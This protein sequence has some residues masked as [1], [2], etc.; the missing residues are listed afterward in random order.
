MTAPIPSNA[1]KPLV[2]CADDYALDAGVSQAIRTLAR[3]GRLSATS[4]MTLSPRWRE[5][6]AAL[7]ELR[8]CIDVGLHLDWTSPFALRTGH[9]MPLARAMG[10]ALLG[11]FAFTQACDVIERQLDA[12]EAHWHAAPDHVDGHQHVQQFAGIREALVALLVR[13]YGPHRPWLR[14][15]RTPAGQR[16]AKSL[17]ITAM[18]ANAL[19]KRAASAGLPCAETLSGIYDFHG[20]ESVYARHMAHWLATSPPATVLMCHPGGG[21][22]A[23][24]DDAIA[25]ARAWEAAHLASDAFACQLDQAQVVLERGS[26]LYTARP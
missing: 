25:T 2:L 13:R 22:G 6:A 24:A 12:F 17:L 7:A 8:G 21:E 15:S 16:D 11:D 19:Q 3:A 1:P 4:V 10:R 5:D 18:G 23:S 26:K 20:G 14:I 9:G